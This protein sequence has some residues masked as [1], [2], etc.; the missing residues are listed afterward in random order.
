MLVTPVS[1]ALPGQQVGIAAARGQPH[2]LEAVRVG[3]DDLERLGADR[4]GAA[5]HQHAQTVC[6][7]H[8]PIVL[9]IPI[10]AANSYAGRNDAKVTRALRA[11]P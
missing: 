6:C 1:A 11:H 10:C 9:A 2:H 7:A 5:Q 8:R 3:G 4:P